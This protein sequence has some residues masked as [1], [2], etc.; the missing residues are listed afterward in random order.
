MSAIEPK[1]VIADDAI[2]RLAAVAP[3]RP[4]VVMDAN[5][6]E[7]AGTRVTELLGDAPVYVFDQRHDLHAGPEEAARVA[8]RFTPGS[9]AVAVGSGVITD[10]VRYASHQADRDFISV[11][12]AA[13][14]D[15]YSSSVAAMQ[16]D[17]VKVTYP[18]R[19]PKA[20]YADPRVLGAAPRV[21]TSAGIG[22][23]LGKA[24]AGV[25]WLAAHLLYG[26]RYDPQIAAGTRQAMMLAAH[27]VP[28]LMAGEPAAQR[29]LLDGLIQSGINIARVGNSRPASGLEHHASHFWD[30]LAAHGKHEHASHGLQVGYATGFGM[31]IQRFAYGGGVPLLSPPQPAEDPLGPAAREWLGEPTADIVAAVRAKQEQTSSQPPTWPPDQHAWQMVCEALSGAMEPF[32]DVELAL[33]QAGIPTVAGFLDLTAETLNATFHYATRLRDRYTT[34][35]F[36]EGQ[37]KLDAALAVALPSA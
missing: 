26:E 1:I 6:R 7:A 17:G 13:S 24:T 20:I 12:T 10:I 15:G 21:L 23:L 25:D 30:L 22:D 3:E 36:L 28:A 5:T 2:E 35:D 14:M 34:V 33:D 31:R 32:A 9:T 29:D 16:V 8:A 18:A 19:A 11:P 27:N 4:L 37:R